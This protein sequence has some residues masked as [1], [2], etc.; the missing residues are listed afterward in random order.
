MNYFEQREKKRNAALVRK[1]RLAHA[2][3]L[4]THTADEWIELLEANQYRC[5]ACGCV[6]EGRPCK[7][8]ITPISLGGSDSIDNL[9]PLCRECN[10][11]KGAR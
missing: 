2:R 11:S 4:G 5:A 8:H 6:P 7:D 1:T 3:S 10:A 9:Q